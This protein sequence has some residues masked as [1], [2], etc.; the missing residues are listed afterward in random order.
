MRPH[1]GKMLCLA[2]PLGLSACSY[3]VP[4]NSYTIS[5]DPAFLAQERQSILN[6]V[7]DW[8]EKVPDLHLTVKWEQCS[9]V[10]SGHICMHR[11]TLAYISQLGVVGVPKGGK[12]LGATGGSQ[13]S[14][15]N[16]WAA[17]NVGNNPFF[18]AKGDTG[19]YGGTDG[20]EIWIAADLVQYAVSTQGFTY[21]WQSATA[22]E[23]GHGMG[24]IHHTGYYL[25]DP[26]I[27]HGSPVVQCDDIAQWYSIR[28]SDIAPCQ[29]G[30][31]EKTLT[32]W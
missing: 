22:H 18:D 17:I 27:Q 9:G 26:D 15:I 6:G 20:A 31:L 5:A 30:I 28:F 3:V 11:S 14:Q 24:L 7:Q 21:A 8:V 10:Q 12:L 29:N 4:G 32:T 13:I 16:A 25:M 23:I 1:I 19:G 2:L